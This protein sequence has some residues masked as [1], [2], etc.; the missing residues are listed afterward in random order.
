MITARSQK[1]S[2]LNQVGDERRRSLSEAPD[3]LFP[4]SKG[5]ASYRVIVSKNGCTVPL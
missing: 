1:G 2:D 3:L 4:A 5:F